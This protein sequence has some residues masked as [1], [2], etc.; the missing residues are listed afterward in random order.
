MV[1]MDGRDAIGWMDGWLDRWIVDAGKRGW[2]DGWMGD[3]GMGTRGWVDGSMGV[4]KN[5]PHK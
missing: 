5:Q 4:Q 1:C 2:L 3:G